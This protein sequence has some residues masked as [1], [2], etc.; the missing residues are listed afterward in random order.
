MCGGGSEKKKE[1]EKVGVERV[2]M[3]EAE[4]EGGD[5]FEGAEKRQRS[6]KGQGDKDVGQSHSGPLEQT[7]PS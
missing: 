1:T 4:P 7:M 2:V 6:R 3:Q 5:R